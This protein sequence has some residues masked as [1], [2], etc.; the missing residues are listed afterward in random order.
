MELERIWKETVIP[1]QD[2]IPNFAEETEE[3]QKTPARKTSIPT[4]IRTKHLPNTSLQLYHYAKRLQVHHAFFV[5][6]I[7]TLPVAR[8][9]PYSVE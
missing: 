1:N 4:D 8:L 7:S 3:D 6:Y 9:Y 5:G 2:T